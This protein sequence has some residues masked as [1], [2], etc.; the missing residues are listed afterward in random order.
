MNSDF[1]FFVLE[2][3]KGTYNV[4]SIPLIS[5]SFNIHELRFKATWVYIPKSS[6]GVMLCMMRSI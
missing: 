2:R 5:S 4:V 1:A 3:G 6:Q